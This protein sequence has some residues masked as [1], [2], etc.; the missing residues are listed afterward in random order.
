MGFLK[1][2]ERMKSLK[3]DGSQIHKMYNIQL[4]VQRRVM[5]DLR[6]G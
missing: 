5:Q 1:F 2:Y 4:Q 3:K 6:C